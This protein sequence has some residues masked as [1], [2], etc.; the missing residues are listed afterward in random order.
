ML[1]SP[2]EGG[3]GE[4]MEGGDGRGRCRG[5]RDA[6][7]GEMERGRKRERKGACRRQ[8][9]RLQLGQLDPAGLEDNTKPFQLHN[10]IPSHA[11][12]RH[13]AKPHQAKPSL[14]TCKDS[15]VVVL[16]NENEIERFSFIFGVLWP[17]IRDP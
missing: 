11:T 16:W 8:L 1:A 3:W 15:F 17:K 13:T 6:Q 4:G 5:A 9:G 12:P 2:R 7:R 10:A 14:Q